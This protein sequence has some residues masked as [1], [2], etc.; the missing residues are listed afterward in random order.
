M[1]PQ[2]PAP[3]GV[4]FQRAAG[5]P[6]LLATAIH[7]KPPFGGPKQVLKY[8]ARYTHRV[9]IANSRLVSLQEGEVRFRWKDYTHG[10][11]QKTMTLSAVEF[12]RRF[13]LHVLPKGYVHIRHFGLLGNAVRVKN[14]ALCRTLIDSASDDMPSLDDVLPADAYDPMA[15]AAGSPCPRC[16]KGHIVSRVLDP[17]AGDDPCRRPRRIDSS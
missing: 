11:R 8:L 14:L 7:V 9:A 17:V 5:V 4:P 13:L 1:I 16:G 15:E 3:K 6:F 10:N 2:I 12:I